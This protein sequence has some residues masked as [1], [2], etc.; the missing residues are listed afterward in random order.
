VGVGGGDAVAR[1][2]GRGESAR[3]LL[4]K[5]CFYF[6]VRLLAR[7]ETYCSYHIISITEYPNLF[8]QVLPVD[9]KGRV[10]RGRFFLKIRVITTYSIEKSVSC[11]IH[12]GQSASHL[13]SFPRGI[14]VWNG[15]NF[16]NADS[17]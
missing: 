3:C 5:P 8:R 17:P 1:A 7:R 6:A 15:L 11:S 4:E 9:A 14:V 16:G 10:G 12:V 2:L 13:L